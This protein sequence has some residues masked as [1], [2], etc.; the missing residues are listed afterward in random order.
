[1]ASFSIPLSGLNADST[2]LDT[3]ANNL[4]N[5]STTAFKGQTTNFS[6]LFYQQEGTAGSGDEIQVGTGVQVASNSTNFTGG[7]I[8]STGV[9]TDAAIDGTGFFVLDNGDGSQL[10][11]RD[12][13]FQT[14]SDGTLETSDGQA[15]MGY[16]ATNGVISTSGALSDIVIPIG[17]SMPPS[18]TTS[19]SITQNLDSSAKVGATATGT[20]TV[21]DSLGAS[22]DA[23]VT[24]TNQG[25]NQW[26]YAITVPDT[27]SGAAS[28]ADTTNYTF[29]SSGGVLA[30][31]DPSTSLTITGPT[32]AG[33]TA[34]TTAPTVT[35]GETV[36]DYATALST[37][38]TNAGITGVTVTSTAAGVLSITGVNVST[39]GSIVQDPVASA[40]A[41][42]TLTF[43]SSGNLV[44]P[45]TDVSDITFSGLS[46]NA[47]AMDMTWNLFSS[48]GTGTVSQ[49]DASSGQSAETANGYV[50]GTYNGTFSIG[51]DGTITADYSNGQHQTVGQLAIASV[52]NEEGLADVGST[53]YQTTA[54]SG[55]AS[56]GVAGSEG[57]GTIEG[58]S[59]EASN[60]NISTEFSDLIVAQR[61]FEAN[62]K[63]VTTFDSVT[64]QAINMIQS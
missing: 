9:D 7:S 12:G 59:L 1:M 10:Y 49:T 27:V 60:V 14:S 53:E 57:L 42:G 24:Y 19:F 21:Y 28:G 34:T 61:A 15:V 44:S 5:M 22:Y 43:D 35:Q 26:S 13:N 47:A 20:V 52:A 3:I 30:T 40:N 41:T 2:A 29:G 56:V 32:A 4:A 6:D 31:V 54:A 63:S 37:A 64:Q 38:L 16:M 33:S 36:A 23:T 48:T 46:D 17:Q 50:S 55:L 58:S 25:N 18:A 45:A 62:A 11:T 51:S 8:S 39:T